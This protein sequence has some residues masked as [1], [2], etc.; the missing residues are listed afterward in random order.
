MILDKDDAEQLSSD[1]SW[2]EETFYG[3]HHDLNNRWILEDDMKE[4]LEHL[5][6]MKDIITKALEKQN[7]KV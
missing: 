2:L 5:E 3:L 1:S 4:A 6:S 7:G